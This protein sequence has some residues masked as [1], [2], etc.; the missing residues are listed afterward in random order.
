MKWG[1]IFCLLLLLIS[2]PSLAEQDVDTAAGTA[3]ATTSQTDMSEADLET[4]ESESESASKNHKT[5]SRRE[6]RVQSKP[7]RTQ[8]SAPEKLEVDPD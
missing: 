4:T 6:K 2:T 8:R 7:I 3:P 1:R 5:P